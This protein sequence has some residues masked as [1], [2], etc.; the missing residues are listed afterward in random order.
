M[1]RYLQTEIKKDIALYNHLKENSEYYKYLNRGTMSL[2][3]F[4]SIMKEKYKERVS[5][6]INNVVDSIDTISNVLDVLK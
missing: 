5:D 6:K 4:K 3:E 2:N 1:N